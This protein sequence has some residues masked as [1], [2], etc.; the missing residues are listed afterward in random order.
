MIPQ[1]KKG[2][3]YDGLMHVT[4]WLPTL[5]NVAT[6]GAW[7]GS[8]ATTVLYPDGSVNVTTSGAITSKSKLSGV[9]QWESILAGAVS[10]STTTT[11]STDTTDTTDTTTI[12]AMSPRKNIL[13]TLTME[14]DPATALVC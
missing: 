14:T 11:Q 6:N 13:H 10:V 12:P 1:N 8:Y 9:D 2:K 3:S 5:M 4:D 7:V